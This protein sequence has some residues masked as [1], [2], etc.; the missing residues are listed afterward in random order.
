MTDNSPAKRVLIV[1]DD[2]QVLTTLVYSLEELG[3]DYVVETARSGEEALTKIQQTTYELVLTDYKMSG[4]TGL[5]LSKAIRQIAPSTE[6]ILMTGHATREMR[7]TSETLNVAALIDK[8]FSMDQ[9]GGMVR[10]IIERTRGED[11]YRSGERSVSQPVLTSLKKL[12]ADIGARC[13]LLLSSGGYPVEVAGQTGELDITS[14]GALIAANF[15][16]AVELANLLGDGSVFKSSYHE[17]PD[18]NFY[19]YDVNGNLLLTVIFGAET[20]PGMVWFYTKKTAIELVP[21]CMEEEQIDAPPFEEDWASEL[22]ES[23]EDFVMSDVELDSSSSD[24]TTT[25][26]TDEESNHFIGRELP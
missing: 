1:D 6:V 3:S 13:V 18:Y 12:Q 2:P 11:P 24:S 23:F 25:Q 20:K 8:P 26:Q 5:E 21:L 17:G 22:K 4:M 14:L 15:M 9:V 10:D 16:A 7:E 19:S